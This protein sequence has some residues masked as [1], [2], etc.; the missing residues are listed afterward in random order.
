M[1]G[2]RRLLPRASRS[3]C[4]SCRCTRGLPDAH[5]EAPTAGS[6]LLAGVLLKMGTYGFIRVSLP[7]LPTRRCTWSWFIAALAAISIVYGAAVAFA[8]TDLKKLVAYSSVSHMGFVMLGIAV[9]TPRASNG[10]MVVMFSHGLDH[11]HALPA[12]R[13]GLRADAHAA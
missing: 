1:V 9:R 13:H 12:R 5:V 6:V 2:L 10:A 4:R 11:R 7:M 8:Q 3:R